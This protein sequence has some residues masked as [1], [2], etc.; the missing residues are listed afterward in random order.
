[1][2]KRADLLASSSKDVVAGAKLPHW[3]SHFATAVHQAS[4]K[5]AGILLDRHCGMGREDPRES[6]GVD[7][8]AEAEADA[9]VD[10]EVGAGV[11]AAH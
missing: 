3:A 4:A 11:G 10:A 7:A 9:E 1:M 2:T 5:C 6:A 8:G